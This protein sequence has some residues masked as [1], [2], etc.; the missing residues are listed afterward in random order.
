MSTSVTLSDGPAITAAIQS[1]RADNLPTNWVLVGHDKDGTDPNKLVLVET[2]QDGFDGLKAKLSDDKVQYAL[3][4]MTNQVDMST[5]VKFVYIYSFADKLSFVKKGRFGVVKGDATK[6]FMP[7]HVEI[8]IGSPSD[9]I[10]EDVVKKIE[11]AAGNMNNVR[12]AG[13]VEGRQERGYTAHT[14]VRRNSLDTGSQTNLASPTNSDPHPTTASSAVGGFH[15][16]SHHSLNQGSTGNLNRQHSNSF[17]NVST[18]TPSVATQSTGIKFAPE[19]V[20]AIKEVKNDKAPTRWCVGK[21]ENNDIG[22]P[23]VLEGTGLGG[24]NELREL[25]KPDGIYYG[26]IRMTDLVDGH[27]TIKFAFITFIGTQ[28]GIMKKAKLSTHK[29]SVSESFGPYHVDFTV[30]EKK[31]IDDGVVATRISKVSGGRK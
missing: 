1:V 25:F 13:F 11:A 27:P 4:R 28:V 5:T 29:G 9:L 12:E 2:G 24:V 18:G 21:Y 3:L 6:Y 14:T 31:E 15:A 17:G 16:K 26:M 30:S 22:S 8:E 20:Q 19:L 10:E 7:F 23:V